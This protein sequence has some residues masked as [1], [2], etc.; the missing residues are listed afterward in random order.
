M[1][2]SA[3]RADP[4]RCVVNAAG[5]ELKKLAR[6][7]EGYPPE[8]VPRL[9]SR[10]EAISVTRKAVLLASSIGPG[11]VGSGSMSCSILPETHAV[12]SGCRMI[13][14]ET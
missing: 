6:A 8:R 13:E 12:W 5:L 3:V 14:Q 11:P 9:V 7:T 1:C 2:I 4:G 10:R